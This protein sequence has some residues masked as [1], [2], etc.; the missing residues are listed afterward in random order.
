[1]RVSTLEGGV[2]T[3]RKPPAPD[4]LRDITVEQRARLRGIGRLLLGV[5]RRKQKGRSRG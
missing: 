4:D 3:K 5:A 1:M 2:D